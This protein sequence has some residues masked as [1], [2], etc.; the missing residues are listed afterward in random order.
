MRD[1]AAR[2]NAETHLAPHGGSR[3]LSRSTTT[4]ALDR[5]RQG[6]RGARSGGGHLT[7]QGPGAAGSAMTQCVDGTFPRAPPITLP[8]NSRIYCAGSGRFSR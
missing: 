6:V 1:V 4:D 2:L 8:A 3:E 7:G 5:A